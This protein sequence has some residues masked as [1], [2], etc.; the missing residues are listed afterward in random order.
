[1]SVALAERELEKAKVARNIMID[2]SHANSNKD[3][4]LQPLVMDNVSNQILEGNA[5]IVG[6]RQTQEC[7]SD[8]SSGLIRLQ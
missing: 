5:S 6:A 1:V 4:A 2:A 7:P 3:P 8:A